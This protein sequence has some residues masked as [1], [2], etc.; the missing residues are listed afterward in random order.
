VPSQLFERRAAAGNGLLL[1][2]VQGAAKFPFLQTQIKVK[3]QGMTSHIQRR[4][5]SDTATGLQNYENCHLGY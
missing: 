1:D 5:R 3:M 2:T 4:T